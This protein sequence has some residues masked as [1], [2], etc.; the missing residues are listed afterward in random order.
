MDTRRVGLCYHFGCDGRGGGGE[1]SPRVP[2]RHIEKKVSI[3]MSSAHDFCFV[4]SDFY[5]VVSG[6]QSRQINAFKGFIHL[7]HLDAA[8]GQIEDA[9]H[10]PPFGS[11]QLYAQPTAFDDEGV[12][13]D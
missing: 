6:G 4:L 11:T 1:K 5:D 10:T 7:L 8:A 9:Q 13:L 12:L 3:K 2:G